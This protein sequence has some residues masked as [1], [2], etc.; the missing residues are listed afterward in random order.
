MIKVLHIANKRYK[1]D[2]EKGGKWKTES[3]RKT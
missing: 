2:I 3:K 1:K